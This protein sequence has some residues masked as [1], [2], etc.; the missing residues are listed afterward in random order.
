MKILIT[1]ARGQLGKEFKEISK[2]I[3][4][5]DFCFTDCDTL[6]ISSKLETEDYLKKNVFDYCINC[7]AYTSVDNSEKYIENAELVNFHGSKNLAIA[8]KKNN[9][10]LIHVSSDFVFDGKKNTSYIENDKTNPLNVYGESKL[11]GEIEIQNITQKY[12]IFRTAWLYSSFGNNFVKTML[13]I[14]KNR[15]SIKVVEDQIG[16]PTYARDLAEIILIVIQ[17]RSTKYGVYHYT[18]EGVA[19]WYDFAKAIFDYSDIDIDIKPITS[20]QYPLSA[21]RPIFTVL[22]KNKIKKNFQ[23]T[24]PHW[25]QSLKHCLSLILQ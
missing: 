22:N 5:L 10:T 3:N 24:I 20:D 4:N 16:T 7:A 8:C 19:S 11:K 6:D 13:Q 9:T 12:F 17:S 21:E 18:N 25:T 15:D 23:I 2:K 14:S 1:G